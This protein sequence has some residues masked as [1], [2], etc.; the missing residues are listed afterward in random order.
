MGQ[1]PTLIGLPMW[2]QLAPACSVSEGAI[3]SRLGSRPT[4]EDSHR[5]LRLPGL[6]LERLR[7]RRRKGGH[8]PWRLE[9]CAHLEPYSVRRC[10]AVAVAAGFSDQ[11]APPSTAPPSE[12][13][14]E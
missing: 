13:G 3:G 7:A 12:A 1:T 8:H 9:R 6:Q 10:G 5:R 11:H 14:L 4:R 2:V